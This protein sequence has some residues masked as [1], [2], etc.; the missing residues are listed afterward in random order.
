MKTGKKAKAALCILLAC[1][2]LAGCACAETATLPH[3]LD[4]AG[5]TQ[6]EIQASDRLYANVLFAQEDD[7]RSAVEA[8]VDALTEKYGFTLSG[9]EG[10]LGIYCWYLTMPGS[11]LPA[12]ST[13]HVWLTYTEPVTYSSGKSNGVSQKTVKIQWVDGIS[14]KEPTQKANS[15][16][17]QNTSGGSAVSESEKTPTKQKV[18]S[19]GKECDVCKGTGRCPDCGG[20]RWVTRWEWVTEWIYVNGSPEQTTN[21]KLVTVRCDGSH[22]DNG[23]CSECGGDGWVND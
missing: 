20:E 9:K 2:C 12:K 21:S 19:Y 18:D 14:M 22:C 13:G 16:G 4:F 7:A 1:L 5:N 23:L 17:G 8:Y 15:T 11:T 3:P 10:T 6:M